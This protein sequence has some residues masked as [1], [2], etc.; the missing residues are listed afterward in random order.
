MAS[1]D[2]PAFLVLG[3]TSHG[4]LGIRLDALGAEIRRDE[5]SADALTGW[6]AAAEADWAPRWVWHDTPQWYASL[7][8]EGVRVARCH[9]LRLCH[10]ILRDSAL[11]HE[12][13]AVRTAAEWDASPHVDPVAAAPTLFDL[14]DT[15][16]PSGPPAGADDAFAEF[17]RQREAIAGSADPGR[18]RLLTAAESAGALVAAEMRAAGLPWDAD[19]HDRILVEILGERR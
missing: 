12:A 6:I 2:A 10:A 13:A 11:V 9:D 8:A 5:V 19:A 3:R 16:R 4:A 14:D 1:A 7:L 18:L 15:H 17:A